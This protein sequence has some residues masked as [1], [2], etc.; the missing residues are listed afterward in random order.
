MKKSSIILIIILLGIEAYS[1]PIMPSRVTYLYAL[2][3]V[4]LKTSG[5]FE[6]DGYFV[7]IPAYIGEAILITPV[8]YIVAPFGI[9]SME[10]TRLSWQSSVI[11]RLFPYYWMV[12]DRW[13]ALGYYTLGSPFWLIKKTF[14]DGSISLWN[15][16]FEEKEKID[17]KV[18]PIESPNRET[19]PLIPCRCLSVGG[20]I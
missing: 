5:T 8:N 6:K 2:C 19:A 17:K 3:P 14:W 11:T 7:T 16:I 15:S 9:A 10:Y 12:V 13:G 4:P 1:S 18:E 20:D